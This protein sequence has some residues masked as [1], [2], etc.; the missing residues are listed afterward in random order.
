MDV[1]EYMGKS[2]TMKELAPWDKLKRRE[3]ALPMALYGFFQQ[4]E[5]PQLQVCSVGRS[6][7]RE[8]GTKAFMMFLVGKTGEI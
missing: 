3:H 5:E 1:I 8:T 7:E 2:I 6:S 4:A